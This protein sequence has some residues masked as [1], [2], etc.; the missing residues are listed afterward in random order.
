MGT[1]LPPCVHDTNCS[2]MALCFFGGGIILPGQ[3]GNSAEAGG[4][5]CYRESPTCSAPMSHSPPSLLGVV[6]QLLCPAGCC[7]PH[8]EPPGPRRL[9]GRQSALQTQH[10][11]RKQRSNLRTHSIKR[12]QRITRC[13]RTQ[14]ICKYLFVQNVCKV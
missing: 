9:H 14:V 3:E 10:L 12:I 1:A 4:S 7:T 5:H 8:Q 11:C 13:V 6:L 2:C